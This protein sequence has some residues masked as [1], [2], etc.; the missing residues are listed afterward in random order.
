MSRPTEELEEGLLS[1]V[2]AKDDR[3]TQQIFQRYAH[4]LARLAER[5]MSARIA[6]RVDGEDVVQS[7][8]RTFFVRMERGEFEINA[9]DQ[10]WKLLVQITL[11][12]VAKQ[13][14]HHSAEMRDG[15]L[16]ADD[17]QLLSALMARVPEEA[18]AQV[19]N[20]EID[21][22]LGVLPANQRPAYRQ[23]LELRLA[24]HSNTEIAEQLGVVRRTIERM[25]DR[26][27]RSLTDASSSFASQ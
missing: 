19:M 22:A 18:D 16:E 3:A 8:F 27:Q 12:K 15:R 2:R 11:R 1:R 26:L 5:Q 4:Q 10:L 9:N 13:G 24:G 21:R 23:L 7:V 14:R 25:L 6:R 17:P 20:E